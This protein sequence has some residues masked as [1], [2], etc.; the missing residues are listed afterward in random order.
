MAGRI[1]FLDGSISNTSWLIFPVQ[2]ANQ[3]LVVRE[4]I[5]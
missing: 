4:M 3:I 2:E 5:G 1:T